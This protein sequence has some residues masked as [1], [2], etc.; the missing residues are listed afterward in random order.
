[1]KDV[2]SLSATRHYLR[3]I[4]FTNVRVTT[5]RQAVK[6]F[7]F[8]ESVDDQSE[9]WLSVFE[10]GRHAESLSFWAYRPPPPERDRPVDHNL[11]GDYFDDRQAKWAS[12]GML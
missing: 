7:N 3:H 2:A 11:V 12:D 9:K 8:L 5:G 1:M 10:P 4:L 6:L